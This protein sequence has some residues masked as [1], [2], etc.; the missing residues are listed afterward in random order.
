V[1][2]LGIGTLN[3][4]LH[5]KWPLLRTAW[6]IINR[7]LFIVSGVLFTME[8]LPENLQSLAWYNPLL[9]ITG[10]MRE[11]LYA[12]YR[13]HYISLPYVFGIGLVCFTFG[14]IFLRAY[15]RDLISDDQ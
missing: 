9:H 5:G 15:N 3:C 8:N 14:L 7:P 2:G 1:L 13:P 6:K 4:F 11:G 12:N 10:L